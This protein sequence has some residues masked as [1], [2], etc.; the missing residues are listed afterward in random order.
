MKRQGSA[1][2]LILIV[3][4]VLSG[5]ATPAGSAVPASSHHTQVGVLSPRDSTTGM[6]TG[7]VV[8]SNNNP[9]AGVC[10]SATAFGSSTLA[11]SA[12]SASDGTYTVG[13]LS[14]GSFYL[15]FD[16]TCGGTV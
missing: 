11:G 2:A 15:D 3:V 6:V 9:V 8:D 7:I 16:P 4:V 10:V 14:Q 5:F 1:S 13:S 12:I